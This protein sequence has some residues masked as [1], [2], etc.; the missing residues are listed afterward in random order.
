MTFALP[1]VQDLCNLTRSSGD[2]KWL[3]DINAPSNTGTKSAGS[4]PITGVATEFDNNTNASVKGYAKEFENGQSPVYDVSSDTKVMLWHSQFNAPNRIQ[5]DTVA[6]G[7]VRLRI[8]SGTGAPPAN[9]REFYLGGRDTPWAECIK[10]QYPLIIDLNDSS[11]DASS[12]T[13]DNTSVT[14]FAY[15]TARLNMAGSSTNWNYQ[16]KLYVLDTIK[17]SSSTPTF[18]GASEFQDAVDLI[19]GFDYTDK[20]GNWIRKIGDVIFI[21]MGFRVG[22]NSIETDFNDNGLTIISPVSNDVNDPRVRVTTQAFRTYLNLRN[23]V[24]DTAI[25]SGTWI[26]QTRAHFDWNQNNSAVVTFNSPTFKGMGTFTLGSS[27]T[28]PATFD[29]VNS[30]I[31]AD[32]GIN[33]D[34][35]LFKNQNGN[36]GLEITAGA[37]DI[38]NMRFESYASAHAILIDTAGTYNFDNVL[39]DQS[40][41]NDIETTHATGTVTIN[42]SNG[43]TVPLVTETGAGTVVINN[44][45]TISVKATDTSGTNIENARV[46]I[47]ANETVG[48]ITT[49]DVILTGLT[50]ASGLL[51]TTTF[52]YEGAFDP[53]GLDCLLT[54]RQGSVS[55]YKKS[56]EK[57]AIII[58]STGFN[59]TEAMIS[60][61]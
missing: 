32:T 21:D 38:T 15:L 40:G 29:D 22:D 30:V 12:G 44:N 51:E 17:T 11:H 26:W 6:A 14:S 33:I 52:N 45:I 50:N 25:F 18:T 4:L 10:G 39:F 43:G 3:A 54:V 19:Q 42:I 36:Y 59:T 24:A 53:S 7:G 56:I 27:I 41:T 34:G 61:E 60:D 46:R 55:P 9:Y 8:Y 57:K 1:A 5:V 23:N 58:I 13:F 20:L 49:G 2:S 37:M 47:V 48:T 28:G 31:F 16:G 35:S